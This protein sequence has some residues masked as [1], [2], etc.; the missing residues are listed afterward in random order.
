MNA[1]SLSDFVNVDTIA[2]LRRPVKQAKGLPR[3][4]YTN[5]DFFRLEQ[6]ALFPKHWMAVAYAHEVPEAGDAIPLTVLG[7][8]VMLV[9]GADGTIWAFHN[10]CRHRGTVLLRQPQ[11]R[12]HTLRCLYHSWTWDL[13]GELRARPLWDG[14]EE[15]TEECLVPIR[16]G[17][18]AGFVFLN[19][20]GDA[21]PL[22]E[23]FG[24]V[25][26]R[27]KIYDF[28]AFVP[29]ATQE[30]T[31]KTNWKLFALGV[32]EAYHEPFVHPQI[33]GTRMDEATGAKV[34]DNDTFVSCLERNCIGLVTPAQDRGYCVTGRLPLLP[35]PAAGVD[36]STDIFLLFP[37]AV[38]TL[39]KDQM[40]TM[41]CAPLSVDEI[42]V[43]VAFYTAREAT[44]NAE[45]A[46]AVHDLWSMWVKITEQDLEALEAQQIGHASP[47][48]DDAKFSPF[49]EATALYFEQRVVEELTKVCDR[50]RSFQVR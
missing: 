28:D 9:R 29:T 34:P 17:V 12:G 46:D 27:W 24:Y 36:Y 45:Y 22:E 10:V 50:P 49:W 26:R 11:K 15:R 40:T 19:L 20:S 32:V 13:K 4:V 38:V 3:V 42:K 14:R 30:W 2:A 25:S 43:K 31:V 16:C 6:T 18:F 48:A 44:K 41:V 35:G 1:P 39:M 7:L 21:P 8:P 23:S 37:T 47:V 5:P 33:I